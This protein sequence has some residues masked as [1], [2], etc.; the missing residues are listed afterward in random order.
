MVISD[1]NRQTN[2]PVEYS[3]ACETYL[4]NIALCVH[5][6]VDGEQEEDGGGIFATGGK[7]DGA[8]RKPKVPGDPCEQA[9]GGLGG[10][11]TF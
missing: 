4:I 7:A 10:E 9:E 3:R 6:Q 8:P 2:K 5:L 11:Q 1:T